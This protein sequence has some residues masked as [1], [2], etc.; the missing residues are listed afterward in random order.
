MPIEISTTSG[1]PGKILRNNHG[2]V[3]AQRKLVS[4]MANL[5]EN[6][7]GVHEELQTEMI[8]AAEDDLAEC[9]VGYTISIHSIHPECLIIVHSGTMCEIAGN[10]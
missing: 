9:I 2:I 6:L 5:Q 3:S 10:A 8:T 1:V 4:C 7:M